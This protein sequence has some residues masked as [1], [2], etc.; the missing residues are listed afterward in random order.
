VVSQLLLT[1]KI[2]GVAG[3]NITYSVA[4]AAASSSATPTET[5]TAAAST[6][7]GGQNA[8]F[9]AP[10]TLVTIEGKFLS[11]KTATGVPNS[12]G[13][14]PTTLAGVQVYFDGI[15]APLLSVSPTEIDTQLP[16]EVSDSNGV[17]AFVRTERNGGEPTATVN[18]S[19]PVVGS[20]PGIFAHSGHD[21]RQVMAYHTSD[22]ALAVVSVDGTIHAGD[23]ATLGIED[24]NYSYT[25]Q[26]TDSLVTVRDAFITIINNN[27]DEKVTAAPAGQFTRI[28]LAAK[29]PGPDGNDIPIRGAISTGALI[30]ITPL[31]SQ[32][33]CCASVAGTPV[34]PDNPA[35]PG[36]VITI[37]AAGLGP[38]SGPDG[39]NPQVTGKIYDGPVFNTPNTAVDNAQVG[40][41]SANVLFASLERGMLGVYRVLVQLDPNTP[42]N[43]ISQMFIAQ[44]VFT[45]NIVTIPVVAPVPPTQ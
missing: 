21:P 9:V 23:V 40:G 37:Y 10:G 17:T 14:Y 35:V 42:T 31:G 12:D 45:S 43:Q 26:S 30:L 2:P 32:K 25:I 3:N 18:I 7:S 22:Y 38:V 33:T 4:V 15:A 36:E 8:A 11:E 44:G 39:T 1:S 27:S 16:I 19:V 20:S 41:R 34:T 28:I 6:L 24:R 29:V 13:F 5:A